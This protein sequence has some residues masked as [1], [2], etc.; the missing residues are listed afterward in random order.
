MTRARRAWY[1]LP[2]NLSVL[3][4]VLA[5]VVVALLAVLTVYLVQLIVE[6]RGAVREI[7]TA[8]TRLVPDLEIT[9]ANA[10]KTSESVAR[11]SEVLNQLPPL[12]HEL[13]GAVSSL[14]SRTP[15]AAGLVA[16]YKVVRW[17]FRKPRT[18]TLRRRK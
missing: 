15:L 1:N 14:R 12:A 9:L 16:A 18:G 7:R 8:M 4:I 2:M 6:A 17:L 11:A 13:E 3:W 5:A 10:R